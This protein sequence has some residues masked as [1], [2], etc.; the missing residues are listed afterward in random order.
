MS[1]T[2]EFSK[3]VVIDEGIAF[4][5]RLADGT[6]RIAVATKARLGLSEEAQG[7]A[8]LAA[9]VQASIALCAEAALL[10]QSGAVGPVLYL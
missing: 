6:R 9:F 2:V 7:L 4:C 3:P 1:T 10:V 5:V 8:L